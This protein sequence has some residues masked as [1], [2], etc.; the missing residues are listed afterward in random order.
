MDS[1]FRGYRPCHTHNS[2]TTKGKFISKHAGI[3]MLICCACHQAYWMDGNGKEVPVDEV[4]QRLI[5]KERS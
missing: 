4:I 2:T 3:S 1:E 5:E